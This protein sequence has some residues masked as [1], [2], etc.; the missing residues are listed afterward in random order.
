MGL[1]IMV[2][3]HTTQYQPWS[4]GANTSNNMYVKGFEKEPSI[5]D[6]DSWTVISEWIVI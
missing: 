3:Y 2:G 5:T 6:D 4:E 1:W